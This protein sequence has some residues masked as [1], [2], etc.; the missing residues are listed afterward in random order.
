MDTYH[1]LYVSVQTVNFV[2]VVDHTTHVLL[3]NILQTDISQ[4]I[5]GTVT[6]FFLS[7]SSFTAPG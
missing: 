1:A 6:L 5:L 7:L 3:K 4:L 2:T